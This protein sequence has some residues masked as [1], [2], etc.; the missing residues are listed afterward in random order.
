MFLLIFIIILFILEIAA[1]IEVGSQIGVFQV[2]LWIVVSAV[3]GINRVKHYLY[4]MSK[5]RSD[6]QPDKKA[7]EVLFHG[8][9]GII[10]SALLIIPGFVSDIIGCLFLLPFVRSLLRD[11]ILNGFVGAYTFGL[12]DTDD[13]R[14]MK[15]HFHEK[16][17]KN[18]KPPH[19]IKDKEV[20]EA[21]FEV[22]DKDKK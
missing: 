1:F 2:I 5:N 7:V 13:L 9:V 14:D 21:D 4:L 8:F 3:F 16:K 18:V 10:G 12:V 6:E 15:S 19:F 17:N 22:L 20:V 11:I